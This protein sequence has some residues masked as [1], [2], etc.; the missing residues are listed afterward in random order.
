MTLIKNPTKK[1]NK[2]K[3]QMQFQ[4]PIKTT[5]IHFHK[6]SMNPITKNTKKYSTLTG[7]TCENLGEFQPL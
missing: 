7:C 3:I 2:K 4:K 1:L 6:F 5:K